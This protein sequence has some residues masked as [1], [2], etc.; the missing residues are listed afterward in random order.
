M[1]NEETSG[2]PFDVGFIPAIAAWENQGEAAPLEGWTAQELESSGAP[3][4]LPLAAWWPALDRLATARRARPGWPQ[5]LDDRLTDFVRMLLRFTRPDGRPSALGAAPAGFRTP[6]SSWSKIASAF[7][8]GDVHRVLSWWFP[9]RDFEP[10][11]PP[12]PAWSSPD[13]ALGVLRADWTPRGDFLTFD[14]RE[15]GGGTRFELYGA[16]VPWLGPNWAAPGPPGSPTP[17]SAA[18]PT[19]WA[20]NSSADVAEWTFRAGDLQVT[21]LALMLR[22][23]RLAILADQVEGARS[24]ETLETRLAVP[25]GL[26]VATIPDAEALL[27]RTGGPGKSAQV[28]PIG[29]GRLTFDAE[30]RRLVLPQVPVEGRAWLPLVVSWDHARHRKPLQ[31]RRLT[32]AEQGQAC[33]PEAAWAARVSWGRAETF[34]VYRSLGPATRRS[35]L[36]CSTTARFLVGRFT[37]E[38]DVDVIVTLP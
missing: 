15:D 37:P 16:G 36:G 35:F 1:L 11:P 10:V 2:P 24:A 18:E 28:I 8:A 21:R 7:P 20:T 9:R 17:T 34:V 13:R 5:P 33:P 27:L 23:R 12:L 3:T 6:A 32:V 29:L 31:W 25:E 26:A 14:Q 38:G 30:S 4:R 19:A 22:G